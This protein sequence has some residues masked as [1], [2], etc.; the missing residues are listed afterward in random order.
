MGCHTWH[1][2]RVPLSR[3]EATQLAYVRL[4]Q[5][6]TKLRAFVVQEVA[7]VELTWR[8][9]EAWDAHT[10]T[11]Q[12][13]LENDDWT[14]VAEMVCDQL[15]GHTTEY[16]G[17]FYQDISCDGTQSPDTY[18]EH[19]S[20]RIDAYPEEYLFSLEQTLAYIQKL[21]G[22]GQYVDIWEENDS[23]GYGGPIPET[24]KRLEEFWRRYPDGMITFG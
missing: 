9:L 23:A 11:Y 12:E 18:T 20:F 8:S 2:K 14:T 19:D 13:R 3:E 15:P 5:M 10:A 21:Q 16:E 4:E 6:K 7:K 22:E 1:W 24:Y 17:Q